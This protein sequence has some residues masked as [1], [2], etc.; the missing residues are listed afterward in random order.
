MKLEE[1]FNEDEALTYEELMAR[2]SEV[3]AKFVDLKEGEYVSRQKYEDELAAKAS[4]IETLNG[5]LG[6]RDTDL[7]ELQQKLAEAG[8]DAEKLAALTTDFDSLKGKYDAEIK[9]YKNQLKQQAYQF[10]VKE[11]ANSKKF[12]SNAA[13]RD[14]EQSLIAANLKMEDGAI[15]GA[16]DFVKKYTEANADAFVVDTPEPEPMPEPEA[17]PMF[18]DASQGP[19][20][21]PVNS[22]D[23]LNAFHFTGVR[24]DPVE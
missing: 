20:I 2:I 24:P 9:E 10:A 19:E 18:A 1:A 22:N 14:F 7:A 15:F 4:E 16:E 3:G 13:R 5:T 23:F 12:T 11:F 17:K 6:S 8:T 21:P